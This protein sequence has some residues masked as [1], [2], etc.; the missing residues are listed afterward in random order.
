MLFRSFEFTVGHRSVFDDGISELG[1][2]YSDCNGVP[3]IKCGTEFDKI[4]NTLDITDELKNPYGVY[5]IQ[6]IDHPGY[7]IGSL[8]NEQHWID[9]VTDTMKHQDQIKS[10]TLNRFI[11]NQIETTTII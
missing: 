4:S 10:F 3:M 6:L 5:R 2:L 7:Q 8:E 9:F 11:N 1:A